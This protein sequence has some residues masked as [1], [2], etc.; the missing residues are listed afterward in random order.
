[1]S[2]LLTAEGL[3]LHFGKV[4]ALDDVALEIHP[5]EVVVGRVITAQGEVGVG[6][7]EKAGDVPATG[8]A[9]ERFCLQSLALS[10]KRVE[11]PLGGADQVQLQGG[12]QLATHL[13]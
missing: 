8:Q 6:G 4:A 2:A 13:G 1:M 3:H 7:N 11:N 5:G 10:S 9:I 12:H